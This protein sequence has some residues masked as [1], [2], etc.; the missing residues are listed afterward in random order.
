MGEKG[1]GWKE[2]NERMSEREGGGEK[3]GLGR[4]G[5][6]GMGWGAVSYF[7]YHLKKKVVRIAISGTVKSG[8]E[9]IILQYSLLKPT[10]LLSFCLSLSLCVFDTVF[11]VV[12][13]FR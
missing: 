13:V 12:C 10:T 11:V 8:P 5:R 2:E 7:H 9:L 6:E 1:I 3:K 4:W